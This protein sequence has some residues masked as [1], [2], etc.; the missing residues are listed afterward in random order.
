MKNG[1]A[2]RI[3]NRRQLYFMLL[4]PVAY[5]IIFQYIPMLGLQIGFK[6]FDSAAGI[7]GSEWVGLK[8]FLKFFNSYQFERVLKNTLIV[9]VYHLIAG[10]PIPIIFALLLNAVRSRIYKKTIQM[11]TYLP[12]FIS[13]VVL[14]GITLQM[15]DSRI[16]LVS[17]IFSLLTGNAMPELLGNPN[18]FPHLYVWS[19]IWQNTG[20]N[21]IIYIAALAGVDSE[22]HEAATVDGASRFKRVL[23]IDLPS[24][25]P[26]ATILLIMN[27][28]KMMSIGFEKV[29]LLQNPLNL[30]TSEIISTYVYKVGLTGFS[31][32]SYATA[33]G[34]FNSIINF[35]LIII[36][37]Q[38]SKKVS[39]SS[40][41]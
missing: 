38:I 20:W 30:R 15:F 12:H 32:F 17:K 2:K 41:W 33:I 8:N 40:L 35:L 4:L 39:D 26:T 19:G 18:A 7:W 24:I 36:V 34:L 3:I 10:F 29:Y 28:G 22:L 6:K 25:I 16:G 5:V 9:S 23:H 1:L 21:S 37:N 11:I 31:D 14:V 13:V 27:A